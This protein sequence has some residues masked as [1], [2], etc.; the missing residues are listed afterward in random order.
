MKNDTEI[1]NVNDTS[2]DDLKQLVDNIINTPLSEKIEKHIND[3]KWDIEST[4]EKIKDN[5]SISNNTKKEFEKLYD[6]NIDGFSSVKDLIGDSS[7]LISRNVNDK[8]N[9]IESS[10]KVYQHEI[11]QLVKDCSKSF[12]ILKNEVD[13]DLLHTDNRFNNVEIILDNQTI[14]TTKKIELIQKELNENSYEL[15]NLSSQFAY[16]CRKNSILQIGI[17]IVSIV[18]LILITLLIYIY[19]GFVAKT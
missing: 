11:I 13:K 4:K 1:L 2:M 6:E 17:I 7:K 9:D 14:N 8:F 16:Q 15:K 19:F 10:L 3:L 12:E 5:I 18:N